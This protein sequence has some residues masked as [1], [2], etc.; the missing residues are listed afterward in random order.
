MKFPFRF[1]LLVIT[2]ALTG[3]TMAYMIM[4]SAD[5]IA[6]YGYPL[7]LWL[8]IWPTFLGA[9]FAADLMADP[10]THQYPRSE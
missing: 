5:W 2:L 6:P 9:R 7:G 4:P 1:L 8:L 10:V 3:A